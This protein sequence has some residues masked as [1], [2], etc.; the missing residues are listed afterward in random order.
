MNVEALRARGLMI[1]SDAHLAELSTRIDEAE[2][3]AMRSPRSLI[4]DF[5]VRLSIG[6]A[7]GLV[8]EIQRIRR[9]LGVDE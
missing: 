6:E 4:P 1:I 8:S 3:E 9:V 7:R 5:Y 2:R